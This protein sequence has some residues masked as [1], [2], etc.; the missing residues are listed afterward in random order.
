GQHAV[1]DAINFGAKITGCTSHF[2]DERVDHG[3]IILQEAVK[4]DD[5]DDEETLHEKIRE[6]E[7]Q[8]FPEAMQRV[9]KM[10]LASNALCGSSMHNGK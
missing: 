1:R 2:V 6:K 10:I 8:V 4:I 9:A 3:A 5:D 7:H